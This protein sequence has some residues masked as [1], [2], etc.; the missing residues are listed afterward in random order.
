MVALA[1]LRIVLLVE[2]RVG[3]VLEC[4]DHRQWNVLQCR[5]HEITRIADVGGSGIV[6]LPDQIC[7]R[8]KL[9]FVIERNIEAVVTHAVVQDKSVVQLPLVLQVNAG[10][11]PAV[12]TVGGYR[13]RRG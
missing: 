9:V 7:A 1:L 12:S 6:N 5:R 11:Q 3:G 8:A 4:F 13:D 2:R 10:G